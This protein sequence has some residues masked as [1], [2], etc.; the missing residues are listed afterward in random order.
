MLVFA[1]S[2]VSAPAH[3]C[4]GAEGTAMASAHG[5]AGH[6]DPT[7]CA[8]NAELVGSCCSYS[9]NMMAQRVHADGAETTLTAFFTQTSEMLASKV[10]A[11]WSVGDYRVIANSVMEGADTAGALVVKGKVLEVDGVKYLLVT[12]V[13]KSNT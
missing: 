9:T 10:A 12:T 11:P 2:F 7:H 8:K 4:P 6:A 5:D 1:L 3:A 13:E